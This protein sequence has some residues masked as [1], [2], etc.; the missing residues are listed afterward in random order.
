MY[1]NSF[2]GNSGKL[3]VGVYV[4]MT[5]GWKMRN[6]L[7]RKRV[8]EGNTFPLKFHLRLHNKLHRSSCVKLK[9]QN[10][11]FIHQ[12]S[13]SPVFSKK[14][15][16]IKSQVSSRYK[17]NIKKLLHKLNMKIQQPKKKS[18]ILEKFTYSWLWKVKYWSYLRLM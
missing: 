5:D 17:H 12:F 3:N 1:E 10:Y 15:K 13:L 11:I 6:S 8:K 4:L 14:K 16:K 7:L 18:S 9:T 2:P